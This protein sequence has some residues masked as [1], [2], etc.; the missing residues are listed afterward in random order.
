MLFILRLIVRKVAMD[1]GKFP[2]LYRRLC[3]PRGCE[4]TEYLRRHGNF[5]E[6]KLKHLRVS[7]FY[8]NSSPIQQ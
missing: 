7:Y 6:L 2:N 4:Y 1:Y 3:Q 8:G 5:I